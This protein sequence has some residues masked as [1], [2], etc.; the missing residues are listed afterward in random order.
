MIEQVRAVLPGATDPVHF[1]DL[2]REV[3][4]RETAGP[5]QVRQG[6]VRRSRAMFVAY[7]AG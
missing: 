7:Y 3:E 4:F 6:V 2:H 5:I 1:K